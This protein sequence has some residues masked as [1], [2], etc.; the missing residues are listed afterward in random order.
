MNMIN[1]SLHYDAEMMGTMVTTSMLLTAAGQEAVL[2]LKRLTELVRLGIQ[3]T[4]EP[5]A[6]ATQQPVPVVTNDNVVEDE[7]PM[8]GVRDADEAQANNPTP[9]QNQDGSLREVTRHQ[10][11]GFHWPFPGR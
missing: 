11:R 10:R 3:A 1:R 9:T 2:T 7:T 6:Q 4:R 5:P 8:E